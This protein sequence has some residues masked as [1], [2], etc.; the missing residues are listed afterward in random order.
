MDDQVRALEGIAE[1]ALPGGVFR[2]KISEDTT[3]LA[4]LSG[5]MRLHHI[6]IVPGDKV[7]VEMSHYDQRRGRIVRRL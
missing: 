7:L 4:H 5:K 3:V 1:E 2:V 6:R